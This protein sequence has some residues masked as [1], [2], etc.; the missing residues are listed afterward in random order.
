MSAPFQP[1]VV[2]PIIQRLKAMQPQTGVKSVAGV[3]GLGQAL[4]GL[5]VSPSQF[6]VRTAGAAQ[7]S[8]GHAHA[9]IQD[10]TI[11]FDVITGTTLAALRDAS[12]DLDAI[13]RTT[14]DALIGWM[15]PAGDD[16]VQFV[17]EG[18]AQLDL[19]RTL[20]FWRQSFRF[21]LTLRSP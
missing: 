15:H 8:S 11:S 17:S 16:L 18:I 14:L 10:A 5:R 13:A 12:S 2:E 19:P 21:G 6:V 9:L 7:P 1:F 20:H 3:M 4:D